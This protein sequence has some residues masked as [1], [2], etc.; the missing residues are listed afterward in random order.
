VN[1]EE[2]KEVREVKEKRDGNTEVTEERTQRAQRFVEKNRE[3]KSTDP[4]K[5]RVNRSGRATE[6]AEEGKTAEGSLDYATRRAKVRRGRK[7][8]VAALGMTVCGWG[9][10]K[11]RS[12]RCAR[13]DNLWVGGA[14]GR[15][16]R[17]APLPLRS[18][19]QAGQAG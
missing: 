2:V 11:R 7:S 17:V 18:P 10:R 12:G 15:E 14:H 16:G 1:F 19:G 8:R 9:A 6:S 3:I 13:D 4:S 5:L